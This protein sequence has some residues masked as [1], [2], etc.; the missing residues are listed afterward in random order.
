MTWKTSAPA[1]S[2][3]DMLVE[4]GKVRDNWSV[5]ETTIDVDHY[6]MASPL[7]AND[8]EHKQV[9]LNEV[10]SDPT[11]Q[12]DK[13]FLYTKNDGGDTELFYEDAASNVIQMTKD[14]KI[15]SDNVA[16]GGLTPVAWGYFNA[17]GGLINGKNL[18]VSLVATGTFTIDIQNYTP[19]S[20]DYCVIGSTLYASA[21]STFSVNS[22]VS[23]TQF[24]INTRNQNGVVLS[25]PFMVTVFDA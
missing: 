8:G 10:T 16:P 23:A 4:L 24:V 6:T 9:T 19:S 15:D 12:T 21:R 2:G 25:L 1:S 11:A 22:L 5:I 3:S 7:S 17:N 20:T 14:G 18:V 13:G